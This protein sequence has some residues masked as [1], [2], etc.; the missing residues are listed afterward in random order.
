MNVPFVLLGELL[1]R[2]REDKNGV[3]VEIVESTSSGSWALV[4]QRTADVV[5]VA[6]MQGNEVPRSLHVRN[7]R[8]VAALP[9]SHPLAGA[10]RLNLEDLRCERFILGAND[11][12]PDLH[13]Y[14]GRR[15]A[16]WVL[17]L[18]YNCVA[19]VSAI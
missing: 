11:I 9:E 6:K 16:K 5:F 3:S 1:E 4:Q 7:G 14:L 10:D 19:S 13:E 17:N 12:G 8:M 2:F 18:R 15:M